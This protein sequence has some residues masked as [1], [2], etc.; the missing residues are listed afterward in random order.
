M[1][2]QAEIKE[3]LDELNEQP[4]DELEDQDLDFK[5]W[6]ERSM[7]DA[8]D[9]VVEMAICMANGGGGTVVFGVNDKVVGREKA[10][11]GVPL[12]V[13]INKL[14]K[15]VY[16][17][18]DP[19]LTPVFEDMV[20]PEGTG[21]LLIMHIFQG[22]PPYTDTSGRGKV[23]VGKDCMPLTGTLR[24]KIMV[25]TGESDYT[26]EII[27]GPVESH[28]SPSALEQL[29][30]TA[31][32]EK[33]PEEL[34][35]LSD[36]D[37]LNVLG[38]IKSG[39]LT[40]A[41]LLLAGNSKSLQKN[42]PGYL[43]THLRMSTDTD[44]KDRMDGRDA[45]AVA[46]NRIMDR[47]M[48]DNPITTV[49]YGMYHFEYRTYPEIA[50]REALMNAFCHTDYR[51]PGPIMIKQ[52]HNKLEISNLGGF[53]GGISPENILHHTPAA[54]NPRLVD[55]LTKLRLVNRSN[56]GIQRMYSALLIEGKEPPAIEEMGE[57][58]K[59]S[60]LAGAL[61]APFRAFVAEESK[62]GILLTVDHLLILH[63]LFRHTEVTTYEAS[64]VCQR[65]E[66]EVREI[67]SEMERSFGYLYR[68]GAGKGT[69]WT[70]RPELYRKIAAPGFPERDRRIDWEAAKT[71]VLSILKQ[72]CERGEKGL[73]NAEI[74]K[75]THFDRN[76]VLRLM[77]ELIAENVGVKLSGKGK[78]AYYTFN[79]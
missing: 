31:R 15:A 14:K 51:M 12:E 77:R 3:L 39:S 23:R 76:Q 58:V 11:I 9:L 25:E 35:S 26:S 43:W 29:R 54:R 2:T 62:K 47:I 41:G 6:N 37:L 65:N 30:E 67:L 17:R 1:R 8:V 10:V 49:E 46:M 55:A 4:A 50:L 24:R 5:E 40:I 61:S 7:A 38:L 71:R 20:V 44:Y 59:V 18:T 63:Y 48:A 27:E 79:A 73:T 19:K 60:F 75:I 78:Y 52:F 36:I 34:L 22:L 70:L 16:D 33:A 45:I 21:R 53:I 66:S 68:G 13:D 42:L 64:K 74:R 28:L 32:S 72:R 69:Y 56:L 57:S